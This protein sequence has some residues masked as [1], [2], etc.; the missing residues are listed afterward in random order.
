[1]H[2]MYQ[3]PPHNEQAEWGGSTHQP[4]SSSISSIGNYPQQTLIGQQGPA[5]GNQ[6]SSMNPSSQVPFLA[7]YS[8]DL[9]NPSFREPSVPSIQKFSLAEVHFSQNSSAYT[10]PPNTFPCVQTFCPDIPPHFPLAFPINSSSWPGSHTRAVTSDCQG[11]WNPHRLWVG[12]VRVRVQKS[13][14]ATYKT[15]SRTSKTDENWQRYGQNNRKYCFAHIS[16]ISG[17]FWLFLGSKTHRVAGK[18]TGW[19]KKPQ[20]YPRQSLAVTAPPAPS[21]PLSFRNITSFPIPVFNPLLIQLPYS[22]SSGKRGLVLKKPRL[23]WVSL[24]TPKTSKTQSH[25]GSPQS[26]VL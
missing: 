1:M 15:S 11:F 3:T 18:G 23:L 12:R 24:E 21:L 10:Q 20:G 22:P 6:A 14:P 17:L 7:L 5:N 2:P 13:V 26:K 16:V 9:F 8:D 4:Q 19:K 25:P